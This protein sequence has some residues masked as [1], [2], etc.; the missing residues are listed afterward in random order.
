MNYCIIIIGRSSNFFFQVHGIFSKEKT[1]KPFV[2]LAQVQIV[3]LAV[4]YLGTQG[5][6]RAGAD[7][8]AQR[9][10]RGPLW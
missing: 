4:Q 7:L 6:T 2:I 10:L 5:I 3:S 9:S 1:L 8:C